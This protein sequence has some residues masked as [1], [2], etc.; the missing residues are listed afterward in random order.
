MPASLG[1]LNLEKGLAPGL[2]PP[3]PRF[4]SVLNPATNNFPVIMETVEGGWADIVIRGDPA[5]ESSCIAA[6][7]RLVERGAVAITAN[8]GFFVRHQA[9]V[10]AS[11][12]VP[13]VLSSILLLPALLRQLPR[14]AKLAVLTADSSHCGEDLLGLD[15]PAERARV[16]IGGIE[17]GELWQNEM[18]R[19]PPI[20]DIASIERD[21][22]SCLSRLRAEHPEIAAVL[23]EC[24]AFP[25]IAA[26]IRRLTELPIYDIATLCQLTL[27]S[28]ATSNSQEQRLAR[29]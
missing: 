5:L 22:V 2:S 27:A 6:A 18:K 23:F 19:P 28:L 21:V 24:T 14:G 17:G 12:K 15:D 10:A 7:K 26:A 25:I 29:S 4:V 1:I 20:T 3:L 13:V 16:V 8:C 11:V 9:A